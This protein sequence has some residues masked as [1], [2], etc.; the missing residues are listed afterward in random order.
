M[1]TL[2]VQNDTR[3]FVLGTRVHLANTFVRRAVGLVGR[4]LGQGEGLLLMPCRS[5]H[6]FGIT[7][8]LDIVLFDRQGRVVAVREQLRPRRF[9]AVFSQ[10]FGVLELPEGTVRRSGTRVGDRVTW[11]P[12]PRGAA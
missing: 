6:T 5:V 3:G 10:A 12:D 11:Q 2:R 8:P 4:R 1:P 9:T 7:R